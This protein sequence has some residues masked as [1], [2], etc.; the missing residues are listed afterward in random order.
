MSALSTTSDIV[1]VVLNW[2]HPQQGAGYIDNYEIRV[3]QG[4]NLIGFQSVSGERIS[5]RAT[6]LQPDMVYEL[7]IRAVID[8]MRGLSE[9]ITAR[10]RSIGERMN[11]TLLGLLSLSLSP[12][13]LSS[14]LPPSLHPQ[15]RYKV[16][17]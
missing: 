10:T 4:S 9:R 13:S 17:L 6:G 14:F 8:F 11:P 7:E 15:A 3:F 2:E 16:C 1:S 12:P 5:Y